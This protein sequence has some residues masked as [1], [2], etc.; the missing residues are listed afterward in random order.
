MDTR[1]AH[2]ERI[3]AQIRE[4]EYRVDPDAVA[5][6]IVRRLLEGRGFGTPDDDA[7]S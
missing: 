7:R 6:A 4:G 1:K 2:V 3:H 5:G